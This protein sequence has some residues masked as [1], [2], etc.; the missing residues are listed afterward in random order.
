MQHFHSCNALEMFPVECIDALDINRF[1]KRDNPGIDKIERS[2]TVESNCLGDDQ[3]IADLNAARMQ[4][5]IQERCNFTPV[6]P[7][8]TLEDPYQFRTFIIFL[9]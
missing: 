6:K 2:F 1:C 9:A 5:G 4:D 7:V 3:L 8:K